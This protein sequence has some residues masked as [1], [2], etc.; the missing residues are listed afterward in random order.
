MS[1]FWRKY[2]FFVGI[3]L[4]V[5]LAFGF[6]RLGVLVRQYHILKIGIFLAFLI[7]G[8][9]LPTSSLISEIRNFKVLVAALVSSLLLSPALAYWGGRTFF[10]S[11]DLVLGSLIIGVAPVTIASGTVMTALALGNVPLSLF[12][13]VMSNLGSLIT[14]PFLL[15][16]FLAFEGGLN[17]PVGEMFSGLLVTVLLPTVIGQVFRPW[18]KRSIGPWKGSFS[19]FSQI[20]VLMII[21]NAVSDSTGRLVQTG[22]GISLI[23]AAMIGLHILLLM[24]NYGLSRLIGLDQPSTSAFTIHSSQK[25]LTIA[26]LVWSGHFA[27]D[28]PLALIPA[29]VYHLTQMIMDTLVARY[30]RRRAERLVQPS[31]M[32]K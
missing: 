15:K 26:Y 14:I 10:S 20:I 16:Y 29:I 17:L 24:L 11:P 2:W 5:F 12:I 3:V 6:P 7:T 28:Y 25:T 21:F 19:I 23:F 18:L 22:W 31:D 4:V 30:F 9:T 8:L 32:T 27:R 13:C 1:G